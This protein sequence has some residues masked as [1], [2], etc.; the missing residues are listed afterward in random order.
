M[1]KELAKSKPTASSIYIIRFKLRHLKY[2][3]LWIFQGMK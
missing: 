3:D 2:L 1:I